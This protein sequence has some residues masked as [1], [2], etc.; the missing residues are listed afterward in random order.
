MTI[1]EIG[2]LLRERFV[3]KVTEVHQD[4]RHGHVRV[5]QDALVDACRFLRDDPRTRFEQCHDVTAVDWID[6]FDVVLHLYSLSRK[7]ACC[8]KVRTAS[9]ENADCPSVT[10]V[11][12]AAD[13][14]ERETWD[15]MGVRFVG[16]PHLRRIMLPEDW[17]GHP[18]QRQYA[19][20]TSHA[21][22]R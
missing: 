5:T 22:W 14:H 11:W 17:V 4:E 21:P 9:R 18:L 2:S 8:V 19:I 15:L 10:S 3:D 1:A 6:H 13:W 16:H 20:D 7:Q 12:P